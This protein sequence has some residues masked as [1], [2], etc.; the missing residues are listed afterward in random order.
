MNKVFT[1]STIAASLLVIA[2]SAHAGPSN[3]MGE[4]DTNKDGKVSKDEAKTSPALSKN[5]DL[6]DADKDGFVSMAEMKEFHKANSTKRDGAF[7]SLDKDS[8]GKISK[9][10][11]A[12]KRKLVY[13]FDKIDADKDGYLT[14]DE[15]VAYRKTHQAKVS[16]PES[17]PAM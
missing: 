9:S 10:E 16:A 1:L 2:I 4:M 14:R 6:I 12:G 8:D 3:H 7:K 15:M 11:A 5:F 13:S 17:K